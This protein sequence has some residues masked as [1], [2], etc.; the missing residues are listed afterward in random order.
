MVQ[1]PPG[2]DPAGQQNGQGQPPQRKAK[3]IATAT[4]YQN[5]MNPKTHKIAIRFERRPGRAR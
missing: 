4:T 2:G 5:G 3:P 1:Q